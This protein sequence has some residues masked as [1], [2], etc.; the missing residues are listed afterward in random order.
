MRVA[1]FLPAVWAYLGEEHGLG[2]VPA[3]QY[4]HGDPVS[5]GR[6]SIAV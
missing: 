1:T 4:G 3:G 6:R 5:S 2:P